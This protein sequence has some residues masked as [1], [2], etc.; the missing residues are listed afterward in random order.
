MTI[1]ASDIVTINPAVID[2]GGNPLSLNSVFMTKSE[3][4]P[5]GGVRSFSSALAV[6]SFFGAS[7]DEYAQ[8]Q[9]Y[10]LGYD[11]STIKPSTLFFGPFVD[12]DRAAWIQS[13]SLLGTTLAQLQ[14]MGSGTLIATVDGVSET[15]STIALGSA[16]SFSDAAA[17]ITTAFGGAAT[18]SWSAET[19]TFK[20]FST[21]TGASSTITHCTGTLAASLKFTSATGAILS[22]GA[23]ADT[24]AT[25][26]DAVYANSQNWA[27][28]LT[29]WE[30]DIDGKTDFATWCNSKNQ[31]LLYI[32]WDTDEQAIV[33]A[34]TESFGYLAKTA[35]Y[36]AVMCVYNTVELASFAAATV[37]S[38]D[39]SR[40]NGRITL[41]F[42]S[43]S[44]FTATVTDQQVAQN[45]EENGYS[46]YGIYATAND[47]FN[48]LYNGQISGKW[49]WADTYVNQIY[50]N[51]QFQLA[52]MTLLT[53]VG[54]I[55]YTESGYALI[56]AAMIDPIQSALNFGGI[57]AGVS[58]SEQQKALVNG[59]AG[60]DAAQVIEQQGYYLQIL[61]PTAQVRGNRG[62]P[63]INFWYT[64]GGAVQKITVASIDII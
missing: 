9:V 53:N 41:A 60:V 20:I 59:A 58:L 46:F 36:D 49:L 47:R 10:F 12:E 44:G 61:D 1:P 51:S 15:S 34:S 48:F 2:S 62:T 42:K 35:E 55:P 14:A 19:A 33:N 37:A 57:R 22:Q 30:P 17:R 11:N 38:I 21:T 8:A 45:L 6:K 56:R 31:R 16:T 3:D 18:C 25:A 27:T 32:A 40:L 43:Q 52:L 63:V 39:F 24:P 50:M 4:L 29:L 54:S 7:S 5:A 26:M 23:A 64:D 28:F 13:G